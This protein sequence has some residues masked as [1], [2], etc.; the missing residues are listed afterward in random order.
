MENQINAEKSIS[1]QLSELM[2]QLT[3]DQLRFV[4][5]FQDYPTKKEAAHAI[6]LKPD[7]VYRWNGIVDQVAALIAQERIE[8]AR[9]I[10]RKNI[11]KAAGVKVAGLDS[12]N[13]VIR[14][15]A[16]SE[17]ID[18]EIGAITQSVE[19]KGDLAVTMIEVIKD[20]GK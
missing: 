4:I 20:Y 5:A 8:A 1:E 6:D 12:S 9:Q 3:K 7:T 13:E 18:R 11:V 2:P 14:Q 15:K 16:A 10:L 17:I 19:H